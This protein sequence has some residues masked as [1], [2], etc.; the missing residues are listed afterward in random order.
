VRYNEFNVI[1]TPLTLARW[2]P[3]KPTKNDT[4]IEQLRPRELL[5]VLD[6]CEHVI[7]GCATLVLTL[8]SQIKVNGICDKIRQ[9]LTCL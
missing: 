5:L 7:D 3:M 2:S 9:T 4:L 8:P 1:V 6:N